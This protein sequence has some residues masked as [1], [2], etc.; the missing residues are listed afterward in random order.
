MV[1]E[2]ETGK[3]LWTTRQGVLPGTLAVGA[4]GVFF[5]DGQSVV[6]LDRETGAERWRSEPIERQRELFSRYMPTLVVYEDVVLFS[7]QGRGRSAGGA[8]SGRD[9]LTALSAKTGQVLWQADHPPSGYQ[10]P[11]DVLVAGGLVWCGETTGGSGVF[12]GRD[13]RTGEVKAEF[14]PDTDVFWFHHRCYRGKATEN[15]LLMS[16][17]GT[18]FV[19]FRKQQWLV[20][21]WVRGA[22][23]YGVMPA[24]GLLY[25][26]Q[27]PCACYLETKLSG[28]NALAPAAAGPRI[29]PE[30]AGQPRLERGPAYDGLSAPAGD[31]AAAEQWPTY[32]AD[33]QRSG[34]AR[35]VVAPEVVRRWQT[36]LGGKLTSPVIAA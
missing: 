30:L 13:P 17:T 2:A 24:N 14:P 33:A 19:D 32:R 15:Y 18:E 22:C 9:Q 20:N 3:V 36:D 27:H 12:T 31:E 1:L 23:L 34:R 10:S 11:E 35:T 26:P 28:F 8:G 4:G 29:P 21:H 25:A 7:G 6:A 16:R 5:H